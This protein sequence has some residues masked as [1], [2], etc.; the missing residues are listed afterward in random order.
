MRACKLRQLGILAALLAAGTS[1]ALAAQTSSSG[2]LNVVLQN[3]TGLQM[4]LNSDS[5]GVTLG[6]AGTS[7]ATL[8][9]GTV[10]AYGTPATNVTRTNQTSTF[11]VSTFFDVEVAESGLSSTSYTLAAS[12]SSTAPTGLTVQVDSVT[13]STTSATISTSGSYSTNVR[14]TLSVVVS[15][16]ASGSGGPTTGTQ[17]SSTINLVA[18]SN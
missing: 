13:L 18:T 9:F 12:L 11:T 8:G 4:V 3:G 17:L 6:N 16:A 15:T 7:S 14:H 5:S 2:T 10:G 1:A